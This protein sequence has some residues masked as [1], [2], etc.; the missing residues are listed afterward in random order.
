MND[1]DVVTGK[2]D[3]CIGFDRKQLQEI[4]IRVGAKLMEREIR[5]AEY[6]RGFFD[7][8]YIILF[9]AFGTYVWLSGKEK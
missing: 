3:H 9:L 2:I 7:C 8:F 6:L 1:T 5:R 4:D